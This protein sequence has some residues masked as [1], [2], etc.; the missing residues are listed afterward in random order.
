MNNSTHISLQ[1]YRHQNNLHRS[2]EGTQKHSQPRDTDTYIVYIVVVV[3]VC[4]LICS[5]VVWV[6]F[7]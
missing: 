5:V 2:T 7:L 3:V 4:D 1:Q 6:N